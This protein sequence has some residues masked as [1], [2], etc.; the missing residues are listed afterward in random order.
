[1]II[2]NKKI[3]INIFIEMEEK[4]ND[5]LIDC[6]FYD[7]KKE[8]EITENITKKFHVLISK[9]NIT[10][11]KIKEFIQTLTN[12]GSYEIYIDSDDAFIYKKYIYNVKNNYIIHE[13]VPYELNEDNG[14]DNLIK[15]IF[16]CKSEQIMIEKRDNNV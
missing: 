16:H 5:S 3:T 4:L 15:I 7:E 11:E 8:I 12:Y 1:M 2:N 9:S 13:Y 10:E 14:I 6:F